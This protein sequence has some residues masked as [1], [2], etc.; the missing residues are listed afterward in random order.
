MLIILFIAF[1]VSNSAIY[2][3]SDGQFPY[4]A[5]LDA[6]EKFQLFWKYNDTD[7]IFRTKVQTK[8]YIGFGISG[9]GGMRGADIVTGW[10]KDG[11]VY[12]QVSH[13][14]FNSTGVRLT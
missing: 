13:L 7:I 8:G 9:N 11:K 10:V 2:S 12:F 14:F 3:L 5:Y 4:S 1:L 6:T